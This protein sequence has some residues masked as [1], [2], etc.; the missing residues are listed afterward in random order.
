MTTLDHPPLADRPDDDPPQR[1]RR[2]PRPLRAASPLHVIVAVLLVVVVYP[3]VWLFL[4]SFKTQDEFLNDAVLGPA[5]DWSTSTTT[6]RRGRPATSRRTCSTA[7]SRSF[8]SLALIV[9]LGTA[10]G[11]ALEVMVWKGRGTG[12]AAVPR[13][14]HDPGADDP[15]AAVHRST[16]SSGLT[17]TLWPLIITYT[18]TGLPLTVFMMA[19]YFRAIPRE[20]FEASTLD[21][22]SI[23]RSFCLHRVPDGAQRPLHRR[24]RAVLLHLERPAHRADLHQ[25]RRACAPIQVGLL[26]FTGE[27]GAVEYG[28]LFAAICINVVRHPASSTCSSTSGS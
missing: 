20:V 14:H 18:A 19:T 11:F 21:G 2:S 17:G 12:P 6:S 13:R 26:N 7:C 10:A 9:L 24:A 5:A 1:R 25:Q 8:P 3:L 16:S 15:A 22:A 27:F 23:I 4:G 28:P